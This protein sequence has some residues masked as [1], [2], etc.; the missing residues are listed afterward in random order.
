MKTLFLSHNDL[1]M[2]GSVIVAH[3]FNVQIDEYR[4]CDYR[5]IYDDAN[6]SVIFDLSQYSGFDRLIMPDIACTQKL[7]NKIAASFEHFGIFDHHKRT[8]EVA[9]K[10]EV[11]FD[12]ERSGTEIFF[13][14]IKNGD[15]V[16]YV[17]Q[18]FVKIVSAYDLWQLDS[19]L[20]PMAED[21]NR[22]FYQSLTW[23]APEGSYKKYEFFINSQLKKLKN[24]KITNFFFGNYERNKIEAAKEKEYLEYQHAKRNLQKRR[25]N[26][27]NNY[28]IY[29]GGA[30]VSY[31]CNRLLEDYPQAAYVLN[32]NTYNG[33]KKRKVNGKISARCKDGFDVTTLNGINGHE[34]AG[35]GRYE[36][37]FLKR[38]WLNKG[39]HLGYTEVGIKNKNG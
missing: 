9:D 22:L 6:D 32:F 20:R 5:D 24:P 1:D 21:L 11:F 2:V 29:H 8:S 38:M 25:D 36:K 23:S 31:V 14:M 26:Q 7:Y 13:D 35:G 3:L 33:R 12:L 39:V 17:W 18:Q 10:P 19:P 34:H 15:D 30:K 27:G 28:I 4:F 37:R 16:P